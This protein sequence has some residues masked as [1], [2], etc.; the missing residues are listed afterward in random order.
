MAHGIDRCKLT[1]KLELCQWTF[2]RPEVG[3]LDR[4]GRKVEPTLL[5]CLNMSSTQQTHFL[6]PHTHTFAQTDI[7][8]RKTN[9]NIYKTSKC[10]IFFPLIGATLTRKTVIVP[11]GI[12]G[13]TFSLIIHYIHVLM[14]GW[15]GRDLAVFGNGKQTVTRNG[16]RYLMPDTTGSV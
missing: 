1:A 6:C 8:Q 2:N 11:K 10:L 3:I 9:T 13:V 12:P 7:T 14:R 15:G 5:S 4:N 16:R